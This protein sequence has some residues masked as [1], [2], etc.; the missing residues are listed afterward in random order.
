[1]LRRAFLSILAAAPLATARLTSSIATQEALLLNR[2]VTLEELR[3]DVGSTARSLLPAKVTVLHFWSDTCL[4]CVEEYPIWRN[5]VQILRE[6][7]ILRFLFL[8]EMYSEKALRQYLTKHA[9][10]VPDASHYL[11]PYGETADRLPGNRSLI[12][13]QLDNDAQPLTLL[14][15]PERVIRQ[16]F[17]GSVKQRLPELEGGWTRLL[18]SLQGRPEPMQKHLPRLAALTGLATPGGAAT[19]EALQAELS[20]LHYRFAT[21]TSSPQLLLLSANTASVHP[22]AEWLRGIHEQPKY[23]K[24]QLKVSTW[25]CP[26]PGLLFLDRF[27]I[28]RHAFLGTLH[29]SR[30][31]EVVNSLERFAQV[32]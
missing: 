20:L 12:R 11:I 18:A 6:R 4:P 14:I 27:Q 8:A 21:A 7:P 16:A 17:V 32:V 28:V 30:A 1:M 19:A 2:R 5:I 9:D 13:A 3:T 26:H 10:K 22:D 25:S 31:S 29:R 15:D 23:R 24:L